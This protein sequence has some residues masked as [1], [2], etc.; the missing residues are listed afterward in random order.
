MARSFTAGITTQ[1]I[2]LADE[3][4]F[5]R[6]RT[7]PFTIAFWWKLNTAPGSG[8]LHGLTGKQGGANFTGYGV[9]LE[10]TGT[11]PQI[12]VNLRNQFGNQIIVE[13]NDSFSTGVWRSVC[14]GYSG[15]S[16]AAG[17]S[18]VVAGTER[19]KSTLENTLSA[20]ILN[21][22]P[23]KIGQNSGT[24]SGSDYAEWAFWDVK[25]TLA[26]CEILADGYS[27][28]FVQPQSLI[29]YL[30]LFGNASPEID[31]VGGHNG[32]LTGSPTKSD[33]PRILRAVSGSV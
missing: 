18:I 11:N 19:T 28:L 21:N 10:G 29:S 14:I 3:S 31:I 2:S 24:N 6:E 12:R 13:T 1:D 4:A 20:T 27:P 32:T 17:V 30:P 23:V 25:L 22:E 16:T 15:S 5:D 8:V 7:D 9:H 26:E 33:S